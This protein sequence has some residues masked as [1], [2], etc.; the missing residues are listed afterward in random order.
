[1]NGNNEITS[2]ARQLKTELQD[3]TIPRIANVEVISH[4]DEQRLRDL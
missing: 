2:E 1:M 3:I 4:N